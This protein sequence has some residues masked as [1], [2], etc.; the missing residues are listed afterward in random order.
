[1]AVLIKINGEE[2]NIS[3]RNGQTFEL[4]ELQELVGGYI[5]TIPVSTN[6]LMVLNEEG[7]LDGLPYNQKATEI[8]FK[9]CVFDWIVGNVVICMIEEID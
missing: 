2:E 9:N 4:K 8:A 7:K 6:Q 1:M 3:P 5:E